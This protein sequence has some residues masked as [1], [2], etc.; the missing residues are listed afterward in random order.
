MDATRTIKPSLKPHAKPP[1]KN[2][3][4]RRVLTVTTAPSELIEEAGADQ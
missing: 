4:P 1:E 3:L 2:L